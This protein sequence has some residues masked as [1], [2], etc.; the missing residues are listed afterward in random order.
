MATRDNAREPAIGTRWWTVLAVLLALMALVTAAS[1]SRRSP[2]TPFGH[3]EAAGASSAGAKGSTRGSSVTASAVDPTTTTVR[4][5]TQHDS[6]IAATGPG[7][8]TTTTMTMTN[9][10]AT[11]TTTVGTTAPAPREQTFPGYL[12]YPDDISASYQATAGTSGLT[13]SATWSGTPTLTLEVK[14]PGD[15]EAVTGPSGSSVT[16]RSSGGVCTVSVA[17]PSS[18]QATAPYTV[19]VRAEP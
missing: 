4:A 11:P 2:T 13:A 7:S 3:R 8:T 6:L 12:E 1:S 5:V 18:V 10:V 17:L 14:C 9:S 16:A 15:D 19:T